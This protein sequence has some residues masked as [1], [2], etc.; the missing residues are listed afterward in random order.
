[1]TVCNMTI[2]GGGR[3]GMIAPDETTFEWVDGRARRAEGE[4][5]DAAVERWR[6]AAHRRGRDASTREVVVDAA[7]ISPQVTWGTN[8]GMVVAVTDARARRRSTRRATSARW[9]TWASRPGTPIEEIALDRVF[10]G[11]CTNSPHRRP[12]RRR[13]GRRG[14]QGRRRRQRDGRARAPSRSRRRPRREGLDEV[15]RA[16]G[17]DWR[18]A[19]CS[20]CLGMNPDILQ[21]GERCASTSNRNFEGRQGRGGRTHLVSPA[22]GRRRRD[23][24][25]LRRHPGLELEPWSPITIITGQVSVLDRAD[26]DTDQIMPKQF[27]KRV[28]RTGFGEFL[29]YDWAKEPGWDLPANP[30][31]VAGR[32]LR[33]RLHRA[34]T[35]RGRCRTTAS[36][37]SSRRA[38][39]T[40]STPTARR[41]ACCRSCCPRTTCSAL[42]AGRRGARSTSR[43]RRCASPA[44][45]VPFEI[46]HEI[47][48]RLL[49]GLD[50]IALTLAAGRRDRRLRGR[51]RAH[52]ARHDGARRSPDYGAHA[53][54]LLPGDGIGPEIM[55]AAPSSCSSALGDFEFE[56]HLVRRRVDRRA[57]HRADRRGARR[58]PAAPTRCCSAAVGGPKW[59]T[60]DPRKP[61]PE[62][63][64]LG[65]RKGLGLY[66]NLRPV[67]PLPALL[68]RQPAARELH[69]GHRPARRARAHRR[70]LLRREDAHRR[71]RLRPRASTRVAEIERI[72]RV[73]LR[74]RA[75]AGHERRQGQRAR[76]LAAVARG[77]HARRTPRSSR[78]I[79]LEHVLVDNAAMQLVSAP[80]DFDV[81]LTENMFGDILTDEAAMLTGSIG[82]L[83][84]RLA[85]AATARPV[86]AGARLGAGHRRPGDRQPARRCSCPRR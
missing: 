51:A 40:S 22:D 64:L 52:R 38:S 5:F 84:E 56:E 18:V 19:G 75:R 37:R 14:P 17:F 72:A 36:R 57:R 28:E 32:E 61:R 71:P 73:G 44:R 49:N 70:H 33:L 67:R 48:H 60:T 30:I 80:R 9:T 65:L 68:R 69:R 79:E 50:D 31:L 8:P 4:D 20:M 66:A 13:R 1:M 54:S 11:S 3:A 58:L 86:R 78:D 35:R 47:R 25:P 63:G 29:F 74:R 41:S 27:L 21:P 76:D 23:R 55:A 42:D 82:M 59:D 7:A 81:I 43:R 16:A 83:P 12:A 10:I 39:P 46:D 15:F 77:R 6:D 85:R 24:G 53:S 45:A 2:E 62:Q 26:V 34:S